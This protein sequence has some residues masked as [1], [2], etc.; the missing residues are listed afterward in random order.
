MPDS[1][2]APF[3]F[4]RVIDRRGSHCGKWDKME[5]LYGVSPEDG[6][7]MWVADMDFQAPP[8]VREALHRAVDHGVFGYFGDDSDYKAAVVDWMKTRHGWEIEPDWLSTTH[9]LV[10]GVSHCIRAFS[11]PGDGVILFTPVYH[12]FHKIISANGRKIVQSEMTKNEG[13]YELD[14]EALALA[15][16][17][18]EKILIFCS[19][20]NPGGRVWTPEELRAVA[21][22]CA[23][24]DLI[25]V[26]DEVHHD[27]VFPGAKHTVAM[28]AAPEHAD[29]MVICAAASK[30]FNLAGGMTGGVFIPNPELRTRFA[31]KHMTA[32]ASP[33]SMGML[34]TTAA[35]RDG[36]DWLDALLAYLDGNR[37]LFDEGVNA[38][39][40]VTSMPL[41]S[42]YLAWVDFEGTGM[43]KEEFTARVEKQARIAANHGPQ[44]GQGGESFL[45]F[46]F[47]L[48]R[49]RVQEAVERLKTAFSDLQ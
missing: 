14:L 30:T 37:R 35:Y 25:L 42:T 10:A 27:L 2:H 11:E 44:F 45:R 36:A 40:G 33:N 31:A 28:L 23:D 32:G 46:N 7:P 13:R 48:P 43:T 16:D 47:A 3:D 24:H 15:L 18:S 17:G 26:S 19:P 1:A 41:E 21:Q 38:I 8:A 9:G 20:H 49:A 34:M 22:F 5:T 6:I 29:R 4:D 12:A 39:P